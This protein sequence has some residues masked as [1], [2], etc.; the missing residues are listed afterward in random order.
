[1]E[2]TASKVTASPLRWSGQGCLPCA[3]PSHLY[4]YQRPSLLLYHVFHI[5]DNSDENDSQCG[6][7]IQ[8]GY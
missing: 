6:N 7:S 4:F 5:E 3:E 2:K 8:I 1:M